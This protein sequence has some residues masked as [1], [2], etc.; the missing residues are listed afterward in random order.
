MGE[1]RRLLKFSNDYDKLPADW[2]G[3]QAVLAGVWTT[4]MEVL[5]QIPQFL[6]YDC[7]IANSDLYYELPKD[8]DQEM[9]VL[10]FIHWTTGRPFTTIRI[11][12]ADK[13]KY[14]LESIGEIFDLEETA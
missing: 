10:S 13:K 8:P 12:N 6:N 4:T 3:S 9:L 11:S 5:L 2:R 1:R 14:Y 7:H